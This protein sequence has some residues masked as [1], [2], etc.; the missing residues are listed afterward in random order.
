MS[1]WSI[2]DAYQLSAHV[3]CG[4]AAHP[5]A[6]AAAILEEAIFIGSYGGI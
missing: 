3:M 4:M 2:F 5:A 6:I 1:D